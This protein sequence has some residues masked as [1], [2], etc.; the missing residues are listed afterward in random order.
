MRK[1]IHRRDFLKLSAATAAGM[2]VPSMLAGCGSTPA[3]AAPTAAAVEPT[4]AV[5]AAAQPVTFSQWYRYFWEPVKG[6]FEGFIDDFTAKNPNITIEKNFFGDEDY[7]S[8]IK[9][10]MAS[11]DPPDLFYGYGG[12]WMKFLVEEGLVA[13]VTPYYEQYGW[14]DRLVDLAADVITIGGKYY[15]V[16]TEICTAGIY[17]NK[18]IFEKAGI[19]PTEVVTWDEFLGYCDKI[20]DAGYLPMCLGNKEGGWTQWWWDYAVARENGNEYRKQVVR[21]EV[22]LNDK[23]V[24]AGLDRIMA[25]I[26]FNPKGRMN[27]G[28]NGLDI[29][30]WLGLMAS[31]TVGMTLLHSF[32]PPQFL[33]GMMEE[34]YELGFFMYPKV[35]DDIEIANDLYVEGVQAISA[36]N[37]APDE[38]AKWLDY[39][40]KPE[41]QS[42]WAATD[43]F[44]TV[45]G[46]ESSLP[47]LD[48]G[49]YDTV[50]KYDSF[51]H[52]DLEFH[53]EVVTAIYSNIQAV[54]N[55]SQTVQEAMDA[56]Q[57]V[58]ETTPWVGVPQ[59]EA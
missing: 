42:A 28:I 33:P 37:P 47:D 24:I 21:G 43:F 54:L 44:P 6:I 32:V 31:G 50:R 40:I 38:G 48:Q 23:G 57:K 41:V 35:H 49:I 2:A 18:T 39:I 36:K 55:E 14:K 22:P 59:G 25:D 34:P 29:F 17:Y 30:G 3:P 11:D 9:V 27:E 53:P 7:K 8:T 19:E 46:A 5:A 12:N 15:S 20:Q 26:F 45:K 16:P 13:D 1:K 51:A 52:L 10:A 4:A 56:A 58:A